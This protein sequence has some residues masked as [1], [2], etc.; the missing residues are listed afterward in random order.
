MALPVILAAAASDLILYTIVGAVAALAIWLVG[1]TIEKDVQVIGDELED[2]VRAT[3]S[4]ASRL[5]NP[6]VLLAVIA[7][8]FL[9]TR[10]R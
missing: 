10:K 9:V 3:G 8:A 6:G 7:V 4:T 1:H 2:V 5:L